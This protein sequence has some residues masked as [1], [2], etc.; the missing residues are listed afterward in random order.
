AED[1]K[2]AAVLYGKTVAA[3][4]PV[5]EYRLVTPDG[6]T[7]FAVSVGAGR[8]FPV[9]TTLIRWRSLAAPASQATIL[10]AG[11][12]SAALPAGASREIV[13]FGSEPIVLTKR[14]AAIVNLPED[15]ASRRTLWELSDGSL[16]NLTGLPVDFFPDAPD[17]AVSG[18]TLKL[19]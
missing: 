17:V 19:R 12:Q 5:G 14:D 3:A 7:P 11:A 18:G 9:Q 8:V 13:V 16:A 10:K 4:L 2:I 15:G 6:G 1:E